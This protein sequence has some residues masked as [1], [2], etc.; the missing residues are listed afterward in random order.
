MES[1][2]KFLKKEACMKALSEM[3]NIK[4]LVDIYTIYFKVGIIMLGNGRMIV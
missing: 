3:V 2:D 4:D 1:A